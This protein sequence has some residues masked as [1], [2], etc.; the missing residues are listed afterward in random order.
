MKTIRRYNPRKQ[1]EIGLGAAIAWFSSNG[2]AVSIPLADNQPYDLVV[3]DEEG[4]KRVEIKTATH[5]DR[6]G[7]FAV[8]LRTN[9]GNRSRDTHKPF[10]VLACELLFILTDEGLRYL[11]P[12]GQL[13]PRSGITLG[14]TYE[15]Y[16]VG[17]G[18]EPS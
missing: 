10:D 6:R 18:F 11:I 15:R 14:P 3:E 8:D 7:R 12:T 17:E 2:Y 16:V 9:G 13:R 1:G 5:R 4:L